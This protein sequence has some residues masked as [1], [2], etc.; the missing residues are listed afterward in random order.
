MRVRRRAPH[1]HVDG[2][3]LPV[4]RG[5]GRHLG[6]H[7]IALPLAQHQ[8]LALHNIATTKTQLTSVPPVPAS[9]GGHAS[10]GRSVPAC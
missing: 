5:A 2:P 3:P 1:L 6:R 4:S 10:R 8:A 7:V 9:N